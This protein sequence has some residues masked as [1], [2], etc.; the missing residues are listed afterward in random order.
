MRRAAQSIRR[1]AC[2][3]CHRP[4]REKNRRPKGGFEIVEVVPELLDH[5]YRLGF[6]HA[7]C[8][9]FLPPFAIGIFEKIAFNTSHFRMMI[10]NRLSGAES[11]ASSASSQMP[12]DPMTTHVTAGRFFGAP[13]FWIGLVLTAVFL[14]AAVRVR[15]YQAPS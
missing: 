8:R 3:S 10:G 5:R 9:A 15:R 12:M 11:V 4:P 7:G 1:S 6:R 13:G 14:A 2:A